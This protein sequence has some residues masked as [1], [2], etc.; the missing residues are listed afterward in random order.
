[1]RCLF[2]E[3]E[4][5][6]RLNSDVDFSELLVFFFL[7]SCCHQHLLDKI[8]PLHI[9]AVLCDIAMRTSYIS[10]IS[11]VENETDGT[12]TKYWANGQLY[13]TYDNVYLVPVISDNGTECYQVVGNVP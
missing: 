5:F 10:T 12:K 8:S 1:M 9:M 11:A 7:L 4:S 3:P 2:D 13:Y 6:C